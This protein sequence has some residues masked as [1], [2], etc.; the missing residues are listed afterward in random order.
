MLS[1]FSCLLDKKLQIPVSHATFMS[2]Y[3]TG[4]FLLFTFAVL[5]SV[6]ILLHLAVGTMHRMCLA[7]PLLSLAKWYP[8]YDFL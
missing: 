8:Q 3:D 7:I 4:D 6:C 1:Y 2:Q 5:I